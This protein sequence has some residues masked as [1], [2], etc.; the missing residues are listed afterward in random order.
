M[1]HDSGHEFNRSTPITED[2]VLSFFT[3]AERV[4]DGITVF[5]TSAGYVGLAPDTIAPND[6]IV[7]IDW[8]KVPIILRREAD[9]YTFRGLA[10]LHGIMSDEL[11][12]SGKRLGVEAQEFYIH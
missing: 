6:H 2:E 5:T 12:D 9:H 3:Y 4:S 11:L 7:L 1:P 10:F 8:Y